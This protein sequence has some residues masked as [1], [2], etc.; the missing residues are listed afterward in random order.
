MNHKEAGTGLGLPICKEFIE[1]Q[2]GKIYVKE[3]SE[4]GVTIAFKL[5]I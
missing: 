3:N 5:K 4:N 1:L 2:R